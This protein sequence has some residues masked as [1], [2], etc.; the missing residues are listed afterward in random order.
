MAALAL[1]DLAR[2]ALLCLALVVCWR[3]LSLLLTEERPVSLFVV[4]LPSKYSLRA[5]RLLPS[6]VYMFV[7]GF[8]AELPAFFSKIAVFTLCP[9]R[10]IGEEVVK[11]SA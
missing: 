2:A 5:W 9:V 4:G 10:L 7:Q 11:I 8:L 3:F 1:V 6:E